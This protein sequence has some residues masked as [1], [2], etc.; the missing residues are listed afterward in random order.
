MRWRCPWKFSVGSELG[1]FGRDLVG[2]CEGDVLGPS[3]GGL[4]G[5]SLKAC[6]LVHPMGPGWVR[7]GHGGQLGI[8]E[9]DL[10]WAMW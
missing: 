2:N 10:S 5:R 7:G 4:V 9:M 1:K 8:F 6:R 3:D